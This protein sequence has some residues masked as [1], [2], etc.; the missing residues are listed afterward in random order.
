MQTPGRRRGWPETG[1]CFAWTR[2]SK[3]SWSKSEE[4]WW[5]MRSEGRQRSER[6]VPCRDNGCHPIDAVEGC[7]QR[8]VD[9]TCCLEDHAGSCVKI[10]C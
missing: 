4:R 8:S 5:E 3:E 10:A 6:K 2:K 1:L 9:L 7:K